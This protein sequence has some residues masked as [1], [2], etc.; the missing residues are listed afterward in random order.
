VAVREMISL[1]KIQVGG[2]LAF[3]LTFN[4]EILDILVYL[5]GV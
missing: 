3:S 5:C 2:F 1:G 4:L